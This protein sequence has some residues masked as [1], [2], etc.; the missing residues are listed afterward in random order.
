MTSPE[1]ESGTTAVT[2][3]EGGLGAYI[4]FAQGMHDACQQGFDACEVT[5]ADMQ[6]RGWFGEK[7]AG[8]ERG[9]E[10]LATARGAFTEM[11]EA[12]EQAKAVAEAYAAN[13]GA[14]DRES[15]TNL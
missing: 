6:S 5:L 15:V 4:Q 11:L 7:T 8:L 13:V 2:V 10:A 1:L 14:G 9:Q 12:L 3:G